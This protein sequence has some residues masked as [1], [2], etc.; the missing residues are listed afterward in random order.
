MPPPGA[1]LSVD[2]LLTALKWKLENEDDKSDAIEIGG[3]S[4]LPRENWPSTWSRR[5]GELKHIAQLVAYHQNAHYEPR[6]VG[7]ADHKQLKDVFHTF[8]C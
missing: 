6:S 5:M 7:K 4:D 8:K 3:R 1:Y 2:E